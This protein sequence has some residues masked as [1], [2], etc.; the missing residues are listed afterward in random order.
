MSNISTTVCD[1]LLL[2]KPLT[3][4]G[5]PAPINGKSKSHSSSLG[6]KTVK[7]VDDNNNSSEGNT[8]CGSAPSSTA[9]VS[10]SVSGDLHSS[11]NGISK[12][13]NGKLTATIGSSNNIHAT[14]AKVARNG[15]GI[16][17]KAKEESAG[18]VSRREQ[19]SIQNTNRTQVETFSDSIMYSS[20]PPDFGQVVETSCNSNNK[21]HGSELTTNVNGNQLTQ[22]IPSGVSFGMYPRLRHESSCPHHSGEVMQVPSSVVPQ[23]MSPLIMVPSWTSLNNPATSSPLYDFTSKP[24]GCNNYHAARSQVSLPPAPIQPRS[25]S[26]TAL[27]SEICTATQTCAV[28]TSTKDITTCVMG[29]T[30]TTNG[31][32]FITTTNAT[33]VSTTNTVS[34]NTRS[35]CSPVNNHS[36]Y[37]YRQNPCLSTYP[38]TTAGASQAMYGYANQNVW[39]MYPYQYWRADAPCYQWPN[40]LLTQYPVP[41]SPYYYGTT[42]I[43]STPP[44]YSES[45]S[46]S[47]MPSEPPSTG[48]NFSN[49]LQSKEWKSEESNSNFCHLKPCDHRGN[50]SNSREND[51]GANSKF[52]MHIPPPVSSSRI[53][54]G[55]QCVQKKLIKGPRMS[56]PNS[57][58][59]FRLSPCKTLPSSLRN[60]V[61]MVS[62]SLSHP[63][64]IITEVD[65][66]TSPTQ[67]DDGSGLMPMT[68]PPTPVFKTDS[69]ATIVSDTNIC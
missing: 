25:V 39:M 51:N 15:N 20:L 19:K 17:Y 4:N 55:E 10:R 61:S 69:S 38:G 65:D 32:T 31:T 33:L 5:R 18:A 30:R 66:F 53:K 3:V 35:I 50:I 7:T 46:F 60:P 21:I 13:T 62:T 59:N 11:S 37:T 64:P 34:T 1:S 48:Y 57:Q 41:P 63:A 22:N 27:P 43:N 9:H 26:H 68:P 49:T 2:I 52:V 45:I 58:Q 12:G 8:A 54:C 14:H 40:V 28:I 24:I 36:S 42:T 44:T 56:K 29:G 47:E 6:P 23:Q 16:Y 67:F